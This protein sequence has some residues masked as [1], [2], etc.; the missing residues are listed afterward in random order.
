M[1]GTWL[2]ET[3][4]TNHSGGKEKAAA[5]ILFLLSF[6]IKLSSKRS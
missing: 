4:Y 5:A 2:I 6:F 3:F 1:L